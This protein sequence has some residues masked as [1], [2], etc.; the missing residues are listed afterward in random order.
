VGIS[1]VCA[2]FDGDRRVD[3]GAQIEAGA[4]R[5]GVGRQLVL[6]ARVEDFDVDGFHGRFI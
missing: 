5:G 1:T 2:G 3:A 4:A 6:H